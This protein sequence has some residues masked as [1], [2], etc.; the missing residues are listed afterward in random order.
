MSPPLNLTR[1]Q[2]NRDTSQGL[3]GDLPVGDGAVR[4]I[5]EADGTRP[6]GDFGDHLERLRIKLHSQTG[7]PIGPELAAAEIEVPWQVRDR[8]RTGAGHLHQYGTWKGGAGVDQ[9]GG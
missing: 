1:Y 4:A 9:R 2:E 5:E 7:A 8:A 3:I 6:L